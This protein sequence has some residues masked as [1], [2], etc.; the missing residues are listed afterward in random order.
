[1]TGGSPEQLGPAKGAHMRVW[2]AKRLTYAN[3]MATIAVF[4]ALGGTSFALSAIAANSVGSK[5]LK[6][7]RVHV[8]SDQWLHRCEHGR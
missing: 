6:N 3:V 8:G 1:M 2:I 4:M 5:Q 7:G